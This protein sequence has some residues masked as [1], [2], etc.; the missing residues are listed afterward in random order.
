MILTDLPSTGAMASNII[1]KVTSPSLGLLDSV[2]FPL[3]SRVSSRG[4]VLIERDGLP[5][6][7]FSSISFKEHS[8][9]SATAYFKIC[10]RID[11]RDRNYLGIVGKLKMNNR[12]SE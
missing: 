12:S 10:A 5:S 1:S 6:M 7:Y 4:T 3:I 9:N 8:V 11:L 2:L